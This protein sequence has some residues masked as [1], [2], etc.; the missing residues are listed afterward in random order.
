MAIPL[1][2]MAG[3]QDPTILRT[4]RADP[5]RS[6]R[7]GTPGTGGDRLS[8][9]H[10]PDGNSSGAACIVGRSACRISCQLGAGALPPAGCG[11]TR[12]EAMGDRR[13]GSSIQRRRARLATDRTAER[14]EAE[15]LRRMDRSSSISVLSMQGFASFEHF[16]VLSNARSSRGRPFEVG[17]AESHREPILRRLGREG[18]GDLRVRASCNSTGRSP[19]RCRYAASHRPSAFARSISR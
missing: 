12:S 2:Q 14:P 15:P 3:L 13:F 11:D 5:A 17:D 16:D 18:S 10:R 1:G 6:I 8:W 7:P 4:G 9:R 19:S